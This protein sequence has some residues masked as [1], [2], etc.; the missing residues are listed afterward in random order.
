MRE[1]LMVRLG[2]VGNDLESLG[3]GFAVVGGIAVGI[4][5]HPRF[6]KDV[7]LA[8]AVDDD[9]RAEELIRRLCQRGYGLM[10]AL[11]QEATDRLATVRL[12]LPQSDSAT[13]QVDLLFASTGIEPEI[14]AAA[15]MLSLPEAGP[16][17]VAQVGHLIA[18]KVLSQSDIRLQDKLDLTA[19]VGIAARA[20]LQLARDALVLVADRGFSRGK[21]LGAE[22]ERAVREATQDREPP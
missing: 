12:R 16:V 21:D 3:F 5:T 20:D 17:R 11:E 19:L 10:Q 1:A 22:L 4:R 2:R 7:D 13:P 8:V 14:V 9:A 18:T 6:T 15:E